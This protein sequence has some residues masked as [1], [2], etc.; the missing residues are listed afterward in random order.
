MDKLKDLLKYIG[1]KLLMW[2]MHHFVVVI[3]VIAATIALF[4][5]FNREDTIE[6]GNE[7]HTELSPTQIQSIKN[8]GEWEFLA[9]SDEEIVDTVRH[10]FFGD[11]KLSR[12][13][14]GTLR[15]GINTHNLKEGW[16]KKKK[17]SIACILP[18]VELLDSAFID[19]AKSR[20]FYEEGTWKQE[21]RQLLYKKAA[22]MMKN[23]CMSESNIRI[24]ENNAA[25]QF[26]KLFHS[27][28]IN[29][30][31]IRFNNNTD[32]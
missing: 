11:D 19:E 18:P 14:Y 8:I 7:D 2:I 27:F 10:G 17:D 4:W 9:I 26:R 13:Y 3:L 25:E 24:A 1:I 32:E 16:I 6:M 12:I 23:R 20:S 29:K 31:S 5:W 28:G 22:V 30:V 15:L 21:D